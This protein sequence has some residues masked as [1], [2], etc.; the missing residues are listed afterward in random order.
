MFFDQFPDAG[1]QYSAWWFF[2]SGTGEVAVQVFKLFGDFGCV[3]LVDVQG[4]YVGSWYDDHLATLDLPVA[5]LFGRIGSRWLVA[6][7][8]AGNKHRGPWLA[9]VLHVIGRGKGSSFGQ[10]ARGLIS[11]GDRAHAG[12]QQEAG[13]GV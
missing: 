5:D 11:S 2:H 4:L 8:A 1:R 12:Q 3:P 9:T 10:D 7:D 6:V 13:P